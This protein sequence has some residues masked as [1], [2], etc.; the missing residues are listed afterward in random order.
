M[1]IKECCSTPF[2]IKFSHTSYPPELS[3]FVKNTTFEVA[4][5]SART[6]ETEEHR[7]FLVLNA[8][9]LHTNMFISVH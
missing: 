6:H 5:K 8:G 7:S 4:S 1:K 2:G 9:I 3:I